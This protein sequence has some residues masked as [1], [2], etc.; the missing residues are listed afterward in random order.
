MNNSINKFLLLNLKNKVFFK[1]SSFAMVFTFALSL[2]LLF[3]SGLLV[4]EVTNAYAQGSQIFKV[5]VKVTNY[6]NTDEFGA[7]NVDVDGN[8][9]PQWQSGINFPAHETVSHTF[10]FISSDVPVGT[11]FTA[12]VVYGDDDTHKRDYGSNGPSTAPETI[13]IGIP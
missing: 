9:A 13:N 11:G 8:L 5:I 2:G 3:A 1:N 4:F 10:E 12:E 6:G 7:I